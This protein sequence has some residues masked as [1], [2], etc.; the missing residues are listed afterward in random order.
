MRDL[1]YLNK[2][3]EILNS[4]GYEYIGGY[5][6]NSRD[7]ITAKH[8]QCG[9]L[10]TTVISAFKNQGCRHCWAI[11]QK[12]ITTQ[13]IS[14][15]IELH[16]KG[17]LVSEISQLI[18]F[19]TTAIRKVL[20]SKNI[21]PNIKIKDIIKKQQK[22][23][24]LYKGLEQSSI[25]K[26]IELKKQLYTNSYISQNLKITLYMVKKICKDHNCL[27]TP[28]Q[29]QQN[30]YKAKLA[31]NPNCIKDMRKQRI[32]CYNKHNKKLNEIIDYLKNNPNTSLKFLCDKYGLWTS[33]V[34]NSLK[35]RGYANLI[36]RW[37]PAPESE[38]TH[39]LKSQIPNIKIIKNDKSLLASRKELDLYLPDYNLAIEYCGIYWHN[40]NSPT[41]RGRLFHYDKMI[42]CSKQDVRLL[43]IFS[44]EWQQNKA[45]IK[46]YI[47]STLGF[48]KLRLGARQCSV[49]QID[50]N[51]ARDFLNLHHLQG[52]GCN[53]II[54]FGLFYNDELVGVVTGGNHHRHKNSD[55]L[56]LNR[57]V[58][59]P[60]TQIIGG[61]SKLINALAGYAKN[62]NYK[63][64]I[65]W[66]DNR[67]S[68]GNV[69]IKCGF[70]L[71]KELPPDYSYVINSFKR[72]SKQQNTK[73][74]LLLRGGV[75]NTEKE[76]ANSL[77][78][79]RIWDCGKKQWTLLIKD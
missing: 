71:T 70:V 35:I 13:V 27:L 76:L 12:H 16:N 77:G 31:K 30:C 69:Y 65:S 1:D 6:N 50:K 33:S 8:K 64:I 49:K 59:K 63:S 26:V 43:T 52:G 44:D 32:M 75:G 29:R 54:S 39:L 9:Q 62:H 55:I 5:I 45:K 56:I 24:L 38:I 36:S 3:I 34:R 51:I 19:S 25:D 4:L 21:K 2:L 18:S 10:R 15:I 47:M 42:K 53:I 74:K 72:S 48:Y 79:K 22:S 66:S 58:F 60:E 68:V 78:Q 7:K 20:K 41:P 67:W 73:S 23:K 14:E 28:Q 11:N 46:Q 57:L 40:E 37:I 61:S 17:Q